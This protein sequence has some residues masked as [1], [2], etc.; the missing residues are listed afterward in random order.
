M[1]L[2]TL[3][4]VNDRAKAELNEGDNEVSKWTDGTLGFDVGHQASGSGDPSTLVTIGR[5]GDIRIKGPSFSRIHCSFEV[6]KDSK[7]VL[8][9]DRSSNQ[10]CQVY[11]VVDDVHP[12]EHGRPRKVVVTDEINRRIGIGGE[13]RDLLLFDLKWNPVVPG[14]THIIEANTNRAVAQLEPTAHLART[15]DEPVT[16]LQSARMTRIHTRGPQKLPM[17]CRDVNER[18]GSGAFGS[19]SLGIDVDLGVF[20]AVKRLT[21]PNKTEFSNNFPI[22]K[23]EIELLSESCHVSIS[24]HFP[25]IPLHRLG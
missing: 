9:H 21:W 20:M 7:L 25:L 18:L 24:L 2:F 5:N 23:R 15:A 6:H 12:L 1:A 14:L 4:P 3:V 13:K 11:D 22:V 10:S 8:F 19:V 17:R 16:E